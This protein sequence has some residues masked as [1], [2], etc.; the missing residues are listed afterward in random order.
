MRAACCVR[1]SRSLS[2]VLA[3]SHQ[4]SNGNICESTFFSS[5]LFLLSRNL[6]LTYGSLKH[7]YNVNTTNTTTND[8]NK[9]INQ[10]KYIY[11]NTSSAKQGNSTQVIYDRAFSTYVTVVPDVLS[12]INLFSLCHNTL[13]T[14]GNGATRR[15][16][17]T[18]GAK[19]TTFSSGPLGHLSYLF[20]SPVFFPFLFC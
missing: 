15:H 4:K 18:H 16:S 20:S 7:M 10:E 17:A 9:Q 1:V 19:H 5:P 11:K 13:S 2:Y 3:D 12:K 14:R 8:T 6:F